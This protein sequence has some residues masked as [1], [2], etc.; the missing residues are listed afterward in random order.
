MAADGSFVAMVCYKDSPNAYDF[1]CLLHPRPGVH[2]G[3]DPS[4][5][6]PVHL[7]IDTA[8]VQE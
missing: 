4:R 8:R 7:T 5:D 1:S 2:R 3:I 6:G